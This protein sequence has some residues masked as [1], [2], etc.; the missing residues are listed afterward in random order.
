MTPRL[1]RPLAAAFLSALLVVSRGSAAETLRTGDTVAVC[2]DSITEQKLYSVFIED[3]LLMCQPATSVR[4]V[5]IGW[6]GEAAPGLLKRL[7]ADVLPFKPTVATMLYGMNDGGYNASN[8]ATAAAFRDTTEAI[9]RKLQ[10][11]GVRFV[12]VGSPGAVDS[13]KFKTWRLAKCTPE[14]YNQTL[15][16]LGAAAREAA[17]RT[18]ATFV[19]VH[20]AMMTAMAKAKAKY[21]VDYPF[22]TDGVHPSFN[23][24]LVM[25]YAFLKALG[26]D[27]DV[28]TLTWDAQAGTATATSGHKILAATKGSLEVESTRYP[29]CFV[30]DPAN[31]ES[32]R[33]VLDCVPFN[34]E[35]NRFRLVVK[36]LAV[37]KAVVK[38][39][40][41]EKTFTATQL[42]AGINLAA[43]FLDNPFNESFARVEAAVKAQQSFETPATKTL[44]HTLPQWQTNLPEEKAAIDRLQTGVLEKSRTLAAAAQRT[45]AP[46]RHTLTITPSP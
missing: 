12:V 6:S 44:L 28:G 1:L 36:N 10:A 46:V 15:A 32:T 7:D 43:E 30:D 14:A 22:A 41:K 13:E 35:L 39:G 29:F 38:W 40:T 5:Q 17:T 20:S 34:E 25:A 45:V 33:A 18:G 2:G 9:I 37:A 11:G 16:D 21:G 23:G 19:D 42:T 24:H 8:P 31:Q 26:C 4:T 3:Y 27:G